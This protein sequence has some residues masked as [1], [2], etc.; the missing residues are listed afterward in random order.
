MRVDDGHQRIPSSSEASRSKSI[1]SIRLV[2]QAALVVRVEHLAGH[3]L[4]R[5]ERQLDHLAADLLDELHGSRPRSPCGSPR[6]GARGR[7]ER[8]LARLATAAGPACGSPR[9][10]SPR[11]SPASAMSCWFVEE[12]PG[13]L[14]GLVGLVER[15]PDPVAPLVDQPLDPAERELAQDEE[16]DRE[17]D[18]SSRSSGRGRPRSGRRRR[19]R[20]CARTSVR[21]SP[22]ARRGRRRAGRRG[23]RRTRPPR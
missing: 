4:G 20:S 16:D 10:G 13:L 21:A 22:I 3:L 19:P 7:L 23:G 17:R 8:L 12:L 9:R 2:D 14:A 5:D 1:S 18:R 6:A 15:L 11:T